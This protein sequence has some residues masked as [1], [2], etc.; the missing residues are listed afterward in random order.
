MMLASTLAKM[1]NYDLVGEDT[2][3]LGISYANDSCENDIAIAQNA[4]EANSAKAKV[5]LM[6]PAFVDAPKTI[7]YCH[8]D[9]SQDMVRVCSALIYEGL[10]EDYSIP[11]S[12]KKQDDFFIGK[13]VQIGSACIVQP[14]VCIGDNVI[15]GDNC[16]IGSNVIIGSGTILKNNI[17]IG[18]N[19][20]IGA[21]SFFHYADETGIMVP[22]VGV[23]KVLIESNTNIGANT[24]VQ[25]GTLS[26]SEIG[27][28]C[29]IG[30]NI[31]IGHDVKIGKNCK[32]VSLTGI[33]GNVV[34]GDRVTIYGQS[35]IANHVVIEDG[36]I[37]M[38]RTA[39]TKSIKKGKVVSGPWGRD[40]LAEK[41]IFAKINKMFKEKE[42]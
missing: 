27:S 42:C 13:N 14:G 36:V 3:F 4:R 2:D 41:K 10:L 28:D 21:D 16:V 15:I 9:I 6:K 37:V 23:G 11:I 12:Y 40:H 29:V 5:V 19:S 22:F 34:I 31:D 25:R 8:D 24:I 17:V 35:S 33:A 39:V 7:I 32:I 1:L 20:V 38:G 18:A 26:C 30:N